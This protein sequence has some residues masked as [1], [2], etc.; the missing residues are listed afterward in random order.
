MYDDNEG[1]LSSKP[2]LSSILSFLLIGNIVRPYLQPGS[3]GL[4]F[5][6]SLLSV[7]YKYSPL[8]NLPLNGKIFLMIIQ[9]GNKIRH[10][11]TKTTDEELDKYYNVCC[12]SNNYDNDNSNNGGGFVSGEVF[13]LYAL[14]VFM[15]SSFGEVLHD[16]FLTWINGFSAL[17]G[18][19]RIRG[20]KFDLAMQARTQILLACKRLVDKFKNDSPTPDSDRSKNIVIGTMIYSKITDPN[21]VGLSEDEILDNLL[22]LIFAGHDT[23]SASI[24]T[25]LHHVAQNLYVLNATQE[26]ISLKFKTSN[27]D[28]YELDYEQLKEINAPILNAI[29][30]ESWRIDTPVSAGFRKL[31]NTNN[32]NKTATTDN[33]GYRYPI[34]TIFNYNINLA[35]H[36]KTLYGN[37]NSFHFERFLPVYHPLYKNDYE[38]TAPSSSSNSSSYYPVF[39]KH[40]LN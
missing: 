9:M 24:N 22:L 7:L 12:C 13:K 37:A 25:V 29:M 30:Y 4:S 40:L 5:V 1:Y 32:N 6:G 15:L 11:L 19:L 23:T 36:D 31:V 14:R 21:G 2:L 8:K 38:T 16:S 34:G 17:T 33:N 39:G 28:E 18:T 27:D 10:E 20:G 35:S 3:L 26:E